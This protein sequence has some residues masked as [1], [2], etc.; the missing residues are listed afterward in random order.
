MEGWSLAEWTKLALAGGQRPPSEETQARVLTRLRARA[1]QQ[2]EAPPANE[3][4]FARC[5]KDYPVYVTRYVVMYQDAD[6]FRHT[7]KL[8]EHETR[9][10]AEQAAEARRAK[11]YTAGNGFR[12][13][14]WVAEQRTVV[15]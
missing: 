8:S 10:E 15:R 6:A 9:E 5:P 2:T 3:D 7:H 1:S 14:V 12:E 11:G 4:P 13:D